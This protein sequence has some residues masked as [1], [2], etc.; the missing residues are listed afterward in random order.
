MHFYLKAQQGHP[1]GRQA[2]QPAVDDLCALSETV[3][4]KGFDESKLGWA[5][6]QQHF[7]FC[8]QRS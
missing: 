5:I 8:G 6:P 3:W 4:N 1:S 2:L 7:C